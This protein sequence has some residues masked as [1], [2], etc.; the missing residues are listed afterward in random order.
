MRAIG[1]LLGLGRPGT[2]ERLPGP[3]RDHYRRLLDAPATEVPYVVFD[4]ELTGLDARRD[5]IVS[6]GAVRMEGARIALGGHFEGHVAPRSEL[7][8]RSILIHGITPEDTASW[9]EIDRLLPEFLRYCEGR[10]LVGHVVAIDLDFVNKECRRIWGRPLPHA[11]LDTLALHRH[12]VRRREDA[13]AFHEG[14]PGDATD[15][16]A[17]AAAHG[18]AL[19]GAHTALGDAFATAQL[20]QRLMSGL[21]ELGLT[22]L[23]ELV[24]V[25]RI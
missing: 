22:T 7:T 9:P 23:R 13:C 3:G 25:G 20:F 8:P 11:S 2:A 18:V 5:S 19:R 17:V 12:L 10:V 24:K 14:G 16:H 15:L 1:A 4:T 6:I 21:A